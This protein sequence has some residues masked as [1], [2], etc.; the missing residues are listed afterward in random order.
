MFCYIGKQFAGGASS[1]S[2]ISEC[3]HSELPGPNVN[4]G[5]HVT[6]RE[7]IKKKKALPISYAKESESV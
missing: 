2:R 3:T 1:V 4:G 5:K 6:A 7:I